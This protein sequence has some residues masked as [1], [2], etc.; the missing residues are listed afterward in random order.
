MGES[1]GALKPEPWKADPKSRDSGL[2]SFL[3]AL[4]KLD[5]LEFWFQGLGL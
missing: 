4:A 2:L 3:D 1:F 5:V